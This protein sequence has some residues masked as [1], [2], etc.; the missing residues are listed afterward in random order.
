MP[1]GPVQGGFAQS[2]VEWLLLGF[3]ILAG[4]GGIVLMVRGI[5]GRRDGSRRACARCGYDMHATAGRTCPECGR[6]AASEAGLHPR[7]RSWRRAALGVLCLAVAFPALGMHFAAKD[8]GWPSIVPDT[9]WIVAAGVSEHE[10][11]ME[12]LGI[13][14]PTFVDPT[15]DLWSWQRSLLARSMRRR[16]G[17][18]DADTRR[19]ALI[20]WSW[21][22]LSQPTRSAADAKAL[23]RLAVDPDVGVRELALSI[24]AMTLED[25]ESDPRIRAAM[26]ESMG[27]PAADGLRLTVFYA[28]ADRYLGKVGQPPDQRVLTMIRDALPRADGGTGE[29]AAADEPND[30]SD[31][32]RGAATPPALDGTRA[33]RWR[34]NLHLETISLQ[35]ALNAADRGLVDP[36]LVGPMLAVAVDRAERSSSTATRAISAALKHADAAT[37]PQVF[38]VIGEVA[39]R[40]AEGHRGPL[41]FL[42]RDATL[43]TEVR[44][45]LVRPGLLSR[46]VDDVGVAIHECRVLPG[47]VVFALA[48]AILRALDRADAQGEGI[49]SAARK[50]LRE[51][52][53]AILR[54]EKAD[55]DPDA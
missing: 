18:A 16:L 30:P 10:M 40:I 23:D 31:L 27:D 48:D 19:Q 36:T 42:S 33:A 49:G 14:M 25:P 26:E 41:A 55:A 43:P 45:A 3:A 54:Q 39:P 8:M 11:P 22:V 15:A 20:V 5:L 12:E 9:A 29:N 46:D 37:R 38:E 28:V 2:L 32:Q 7:R 35:V 52:V 13:D 50:E 17:S 21:L 51:R 1:G 34:G 24:L 4:V 47:E 53:E 6:A 44:A